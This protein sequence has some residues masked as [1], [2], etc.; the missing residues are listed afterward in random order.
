M[1]HRQTEAYID[2]FRKIKD[3]EPLWN[4]F[5]LLAKGE[6]S[7]NQAVRQV[8]PKCEIFPGWFH[9]VQVNSM[10]FLTAE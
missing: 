10:N 1:E 5:I 4:P 3:E 2:V 6:K 7:L 8:F 9:L